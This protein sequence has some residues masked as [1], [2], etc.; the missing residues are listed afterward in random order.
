[1]SK[2]AAKTY[3]KRYIRYMIKHTRMY[4]TVFH[5][6]HQ[7]NTYD[8]VFVESVYDFASLPHAV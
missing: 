1:M 4:S 7:L 5:Q 6:T 3:V 8:K 2:L